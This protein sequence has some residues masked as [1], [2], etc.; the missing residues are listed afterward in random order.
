MNLSRI[1]RRDELKKAFEN[2]GSPKVYKALISQ[3]GT[4]APTATVLVN[5]LGVDVVLGR[6]GVGQY[7]LTATGA[8][9]SGKTVIYTGQYYINGVG[10]I[11][12]AY[13]NSNNEIALETAEL[14][15]GNFV[16]IDE[17][18]DQTVIVI[19]VFE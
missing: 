17:G 14:S 12:Y 5:S 8:F 3:S 16:N 13:R 18:L 10:Q 1:F 2:A 4:S 15:G 7:D 9:P 19:E 11:T 6:N